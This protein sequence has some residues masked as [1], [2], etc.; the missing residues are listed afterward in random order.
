MRVLCV[1]EDEIM[2]EISG[3]FHHVLISASSST[4]PVGWLGWLSG[5]E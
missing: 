5:K 1:F 4:V 2:R 3:T